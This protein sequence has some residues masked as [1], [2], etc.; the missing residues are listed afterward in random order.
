MGGLGSALED[1]QE[2][3]AGARNT[4]R[5]GSGSS[6]GALERRVEGG[7]SQNKRCRGLPCWS[8]SGRSGGRSLPS[9]EPCPNDKSRTPPLGRYPLRTTSSSRRSKPPPRPPCASLSILPH[10]KL[11]DSS[12]PPPSS[13]QRS[14]LESSPAGSEAPNLLCV[15]AYSEDANQ[16]SLV[17]SSTRHD[18][19]LALY[20][21]SQRPLQSSS[22]L[23]EGEIDPFDLDWCLPVAV[24]L[25]G[26]GRDATLEDRR[27]GASSWIDGQGR[28]LMRSSRIPRLRRALH[29]PS[30]RSQAAPDQHVRSSSLASFSLLE[31]HASFPESHRISIPRRTL[32]R[33]KRAGS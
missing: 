10:T 12:R 16:L 8:T 2:C 3:S 11:T 28:K 13:L 27:I 32:P 26:G 9:S 21:L 1:H 14:W 23:N 18:L 4:S 24:N 29:L 7:E 15:P 17:Q 31:A 19:V 30:A 20:C 25:A 22:A 5:L 33:P 6:R